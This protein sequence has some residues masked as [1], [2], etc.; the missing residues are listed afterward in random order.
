VPA[1]VLVVLPLVLFDR[2]WNARK[3]SLGYDTDMPLAL[4]KLVELEPPPSNGRVVL[5]VSRRSCDT[6]EYYAT[7]H[8]GTSRQY[9]K[10]LHRTFS[11]RCFASQPELAA[12]MLE[13]TPSEGRAWL[14]TD[15]G[16]SDL[17]QLRDGLPGMQV[18]SRL[19]ATP[20]K[21]LEVSRRQ[22]RSDIDE[23]GAKKGR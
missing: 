5:F 4:A 19:Y 6:Y 9:R 15:M 1:V 23:H 17:R 2:W 10:T 7:T 14:L 21:L 12:G 8:P 13:L 20:I 16:M 18:S 3:M 22:G 11:V